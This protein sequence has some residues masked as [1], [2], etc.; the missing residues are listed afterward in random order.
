M[1]RIRIDDN[2]GKKSVYSSLKLRIHACASDFKKRQYLDKSF[3]NSSNYSVKFE[4]A[5]N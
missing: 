3:S 4:L 5:C 1:K 2:R